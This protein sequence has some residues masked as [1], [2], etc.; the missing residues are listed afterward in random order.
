[1]LAFLYSELRLLTAPIIG[2]ITQV[3]S[4]SQTNSDYGFL[5]LPFG[6]AFGAALPLVVVVVALLPVLVAL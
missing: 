5:R 3:M 4:V 2:E 6:A 1:M